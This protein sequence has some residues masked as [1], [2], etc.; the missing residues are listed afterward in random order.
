MR[1]IFLF[2]RLCCF[3][4]ICVISS[5]CESIYPNPISHQSM[6]RIFVNRYNSRITYVIFIIVPLSLPAF[7]HLW[8]PVGF[9]AIYIDESHYLRRAL[10]VLE[11]QGPQESLE[12]YDHPYDHPYFG[13]IY[14]AGLFALINYP[15]SLN[16]SDVETIY[17]IQTLYFI[18]RLIMGILAVIDTFF[19][20]KIGENR[21]GRKV[22]F[23][24]SL[25]F[26]VMPITWI[27]RMILLDSLLVTFLLVSIFLQYAIVSKT[28]IV[29]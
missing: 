15:E 4:S 11:G 8:N 20:F 26:A 6:S 12:V 19:V 18:P 14:L 1:H 13:Q 10:Q 25:L 29:I 17:S 5:I 2:G 3:W 21:Y 23:I 22:G 9:P 28:E 27:F 7:T 16:L 24:A